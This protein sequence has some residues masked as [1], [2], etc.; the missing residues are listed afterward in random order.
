MLHLQTLDAETMRVDRQVFSRHLSN[1]LSAGRLYL[2]QVRHDLGSLFGRPS[3]PFDLLEKATAAEYDAH[4]EYR[5][6]VALRNHVQ[7]RSSPL[8]SIS[9]SGELEESTGDSRLRFTAE[10]KIHVRMLRE[11]AGFKKSVLHEIP[12]DAEM[13][14]LTPAVR[15]YVDSLCRI[16]ESVRSVLRESTE[17]WDRVVEGALA[18]A[19][20]AMVSAGGNF[21]AVRLRADGELDDVE[22]LPEETIDSRRILERKNS[23][24]GSFAQRYV[25]GLAKGV[26]P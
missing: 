3:E 13:I 17:T 7:H 16:H 25:A 22:D 5:L 23:L 9:Y 19:R 15:V 24:M 11:D 1:L 18:R 26:F 20:Q 10:P 14:N 12:A 6:M 4:F 2:D 21:S 8:Q